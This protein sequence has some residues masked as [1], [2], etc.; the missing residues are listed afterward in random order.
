MKNYKLTQKDIIIAYQLSQ[1]KCLSTYDTFELKEM[2]A[3]KIHYQQTYLF[4]DQNWYLNQNN[5][6][7]NSN[8]HE[9]KSLT[10]LTITLLTA[11]GVANINIMGF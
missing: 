6:C 2:R 10:T 1:V 8:F 7:C 4:H 11:H 3:I 9:I 5:F